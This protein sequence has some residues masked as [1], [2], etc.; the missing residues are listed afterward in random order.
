LEAIKHIHLSRKQARVELPSDDI[1]IIRQRPPTF[2][3]DLPA[4]DWVTN[5]RIPL[6]LP[7]VAS[8]WGVAQLFLSLT[9]DY[10]CSILKLMLVE[11]S[12]LVVGQSSELVTSSV[13]ALMQ[14]LRPFS[15]A[16]NCLPL[17][18]FAMLD[19]VSS[20]VPFV[21]GMICNGIKFSEITDRDEVK[22]AV[23]EG[24]SVANLTQGKLLVTKEKG[25]KKIVEQSPAPV[26]QLSAFK[27]RLER[28]RDEGGSSLASFGGFLKKGLTREEV[29]SSD[30]KLCST[31]HLYAFM[32][33]ILTPIVQLV[34]L[35]AI[36]NCIKDYVKG[37]TGSIS[38][39]NDGWRQYGK[40][41]QNGQFAF[42]PSLFIAPLTQQ[43]R[44]QEMMC[45]SQLFIEYVDKI[46]NASKETGSDV[47]RF[48][49]D[50]V[51]FHWRR[52][53]RIV[54]TVIS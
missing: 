13:L 1:E 32:F 40:Y 17:L 35:N 4:F 15:W 53:K 39:S 18:P 6:P 31:H 45:H 10:I 46:E 14:L 22:E 21:A 27:Q 19:F 20:P 54:S 48:I 7:Q 42:Y 44:L 24:L 3:I 26:Q 52:R 5:V 37:F 23:K 29:S 43:L 2:S 9:P 51:Y 33:I 50:F 28:L 25:I 41:E 16:S 38:S 11:R 8:D 36:R 49:A 34:T 12:I 47:A 30:I